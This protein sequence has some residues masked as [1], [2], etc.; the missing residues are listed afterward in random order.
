MRWWRDLLAAPLD[1][2]RRL[3]TTHAVLTVQRS[4]QAGLHPPPPDDHEDVTHTGKGQ[5]DVKRDP[6]G[7]RADDEDVLVA[8]HHHKPADGDR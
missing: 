8:A 1:P 6:G 7:G 4:A 3:F 2:A 5:R